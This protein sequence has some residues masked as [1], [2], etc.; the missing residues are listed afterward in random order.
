MDEHLAIQ[1]DRG[2]DWRRG[3]VGSIKY[4]L[5]TREHEPA[6]SSWAHIL[7]DSDDASYLL[8]RRPDTCCKLHAL[9]LLLHREEREPGARIAVAGVSV[10]RV[11]FE[12]ADVVPDSEPHPVKELD[13]AH[14]SL[15]TKPPQSLDKYALKVLEGNSFQV[16]KY[17]FAELRG[18][19]G[20]LMEREEIQEGYRPAAQRLLDRWP[21]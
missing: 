14:R 11:V 8:S 17:V 1:S 6:K 12:P 9:A 3:K 7:E 16:W 18:L 4:D 21:G 5:K 19:L 10:R 20:V 13:A 2:S 15:L